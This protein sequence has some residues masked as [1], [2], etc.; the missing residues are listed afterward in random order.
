MD[1]PQYLI[2]KGG[3]T[4]ELDDITAQGDDVERV[5]RALAQAKGIEICS[6]ARYAQS[7]FRGPALAALAAMQQQ[8]PVADDVG[9]RS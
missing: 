5:A 9:E 6:D 1:D 7:S 3:I 8:A 2:R 4:Y